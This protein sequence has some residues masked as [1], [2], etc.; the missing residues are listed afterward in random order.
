MTA[1]RQKKPAPKKKAQPQKAAPARKT[2]PKFPAKSAEKSAPPQ[3]K[4]RADWEAIERDYRLGKFTLRELE[5]KHGA[6]DGLIARKAKKGGWTQ[7]LSKAVKLA[8]SA[9][10]MEESLRAEISKGQQEV[11]TVVLAAAEANK[12]VIL[13]HRKDIERTRRLANAMLEELTETTTGRERLAEVLEIVAKDADASP[14]QIAE[15]RAAL[16]DITKLTTRV[17][18]MNRL[19]QSMSRLQQLERTAFGLD[20]PEQPPPVDEAADLSDEELNA[21]IEERLERL[22]AR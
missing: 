17:M 21:R 19:V 1:S 15:A 12:Q 22:N 13:S 7:D 3:K 11:S 16:A 6:D 9:K 4:R 10:L 18:S 20:E 14:T 5:A 2:A 8:T